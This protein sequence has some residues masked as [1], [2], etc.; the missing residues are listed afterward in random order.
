[1]S[2]HPQKQIDPEDLR[3]YSLALKNKWPKRKLYHLIVPIV[4]IFVYGSLMLPWVL[5]R[6]L[7][8]DT[9]ANGVEET[10]KYVTRANLRDHFRVTVKAD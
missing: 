4:P 6:I 7:G 8:T 9:R 10:T 5:A 1:M 2:G 3:L